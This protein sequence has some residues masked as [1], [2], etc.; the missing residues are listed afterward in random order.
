[1]DQWEIHVTLPTTF[2]PIF[3][4]RDVGGIAAPINHDSVEGKSENLGVLNLS[5]ESKCIQLGIE[6]WSEERNHLNN[7]QILSK[8]FRKKL[9]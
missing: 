6:I 1:M 4:D 8:A 7:N 2:T 5:H 3:N 9:Q